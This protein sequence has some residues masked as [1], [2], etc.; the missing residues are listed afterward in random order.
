MG[1]ELARSIRRMR[2]KGWSLSDIA[3]HHRLSIEEVREV[4]GMDN[5]PQRTF[6]IVRG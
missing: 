4:L 6:R 3:D 2:R 1:E 5:K